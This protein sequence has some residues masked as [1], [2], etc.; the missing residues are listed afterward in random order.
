[1][2]TLTV[3]TE[4]VHELI[5]Q[6]AA[7][8]AAASI[9]PQMVANIFENMRQLNDQER[10]KVIATAEAYIQLIEDLGITKDN[11]VSKNLG[12]NLFN[13]HKLGGTGYYIGNTG[14]P[15]T[16]SGYSYSD[17]IPV[18]PEVGYYLS[19]NTTGYVGTQNSF[20]AFYDSNKNFISSIAANTNSITTPVNTAYI[21]FSIR[22][23][24]L[25]QDIQLE[26]G[27]AR[28][29]F[30]PYTEIYNQAAKVLFPN[31]VGAEEV[32]DG[33]ISSAKITNGA[34]T[35]GKINNDAVSEGKLAASVR[36]KLN[37]NADS[38]KV[39]SKNLIDWYGVNATIG[40]KYY[41]QSNG[42]IASG[43]G[44]RTYCRVPLIPIKPNTD[45]YLSCIRNGAESGLATGGSTDSGIC[46]Y[47]SNDVSSFIS[48]LGTTTKQFTT[49][50]NAAYIGISCY[51][52]DNV[53]DPCLNEGTERK[54]EPFNPI[55]GYIPEESQEIEDNAVTTPKIADG[56]V[57]ED[58]TIFFDKSKNLF[59][60]TKVTL[61][62]YCNANG[63][64]KDN[65][66]YAITDYI[67]VDAS[68]TYIISNKYGI[69]GSANAF[70][71]ANKEFVSYFREMPVAIPQNAAYVVL[72]LQYN[73]NA[74]FFDD[75]Q[76]EYG[77]ECTAYQAY[78]SVIK[79][80]YLPKQDAVQ[81]QALVM[82]K[83]LYLL[84]GVNF[85][86]FYEPILR[87]WNP[88][89]YDV[90]A[91]TN[92]G[93]A[94]VKAIKRVC[95]LNT[96]TAEPSS[97][98]LRVYDDE[99][100]GYIASKSV[101]LVKGTAG[102]GSAQVKIGVMGDSYTDGGCFTPTLLDTNKV[103]NLQMVGTRSV[104]TGALANQRLDGRA[105]WTLNSF[106]TVQTG[107]DYFNPFYHPQGNHR[108]W[109]NTA[110][111]KNV[112]GGSPTGYGQRYTHY[113]SLCGSDGFPVSPIEGDVIYDST[114][115]VFKEYQSG[116]W[117]QVAA[118]VNAVKEY[119]TWE[120]NYSKYLS[121]WS[122]DTADIFCVYLGVN[123]FWI[124]NEPTDENLAIWKSQLDAV[125]ASY[126]SVNPTGKFVVLCPNTVTHPNVNHYQR[127][128]VHRRMFKHRKFII[129][130][131][132]KREAELIYV[133][134]TAHLIDSENSYTITDSNPFDGYPNGYSYANKEVWAGDGQ[135][136][137][138]SY[139]TIG[140]SLAGFIQSI[141]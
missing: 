51:Q 88:Y 92:P 42:T 118:N 10:E 128:D 47:S 120:W 23:Q 68:N 74:T 8:T 130:N 41:K 63:V 98:T 96:D 137:R 82:P 45:Y 141:R 71:N 84:S 14:N 124:N 85:D 119:Y 19:Y 93:R 27:N 110:F 131:Y 2:S 132:D 43:D 9:T 17:Y 65:A 37:S 79:E 113:S 105:G 136:P 94:Y 109:G 126:H 129:D 70:F 31:S 108:Y 121:M 78:G 4:Q 6:L 66:S 29:D 83:K 28:T 97:V 75:V 115:S 123:D 77:Q 13:V 54:Y 35:E 57:T 64:F 62:K 18:L 90:R 134:D 112:C 53:T 133:V 114:N 5:E 16:N 32:K 50:N 69:G 138:V 15:A 40:N 49:P 46:F 11:V 36:E 99:E 21:R 12:K 102:S 26:V 34:I 60:K 104:N 125:I 20:I 101:S 22:N 67:P 72:S 87:V 25:N 33:A 39:K 95:T 59:D 56:A 61:D 103:P 38:V 3:T 24:I 117:V 139:T 100:E 107:A 48:S 80:K 30:E 116:S 86:I 1:M 73:G 111:W 140:Y 91:D 7:M 106:F 55:S 58:K 135:H 89:R 44:T 122:I 76:V 127:L 52:F 81:R